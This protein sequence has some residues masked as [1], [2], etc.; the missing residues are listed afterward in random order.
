MKRRH[1]LAA[2]LGLPATLAAPRIAAAAGARVLKFVPQS[3]L[4]VLDPIWTTAFVTRNHAFLVFDT[5]YG[6]DTGYAARPQMVAG[7]VIEDDGKRW[8][9]TLR[10]GLTFHDGTP[11]LGRDCV[12]S[13]RRWGKR[14][15]F[16]QALFAVTD[17][18]AAP[19]DKTIV[20]RLRQPFP[21]L[22]LALG[23]PGANIPVIMPQRL[24]ETDPFKQITEMVGSGPFRFKADERVAGAR[25]VY[26][27][28]NG[29]QPRTDGVPSFTAGP[30][31][32]HFDRVEWV[33]IPDPATAAAALQAGE[34]DWWE[35]ALHDLVPTLRGNA[36]LRVSTL[37][38]TGMI[39]LMRPNHLFPPFDNPA[40][41]R[42]LTGAIAQADFMTAA[43]GTDT[44]FWHDGVGVFCP[45]SPFASSARLTPPAAPDLAAVR[46]AV[47][48]SGYHGEKI[49]LLGVNDIPIVKALCDVGADL[50]TRVGLNVDYV[51]MD[52]GAMVQRR[53]KMDP[54]D[55]GGW[56]LFFT[57]W[58]GLDL[59]SPAVAAALRGNGKA[60]WFGWPTMPKLEQLRQSWLEAPDLD[61][62]KRIAA[63]IQIACLDEVPFYTLGQMFQPTAYRAGLDGMLTGFPIFWNLRAA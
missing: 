38:P 28:F 49:V 35:L 50:L 12:A 47:Q 57:Y 7:H 20:F 18:L 52:A 46:S 13:L 43:A 44:S 5:L 30:K 2:S 31:V 16:G 25:V 8:T 24:A 23:K 36:G 63:D 40:F 60:G 21:L 59:F 33:V 11:V 17:E 1:F 58:G 45:I 15:T 9:L 61:A 4:T 14:D 34:V 6:Q 53:A 26:E 56:N 37:D 3:D 19:D 32:A 42:A 10:D 27:R 51:P 39:G 22:P 41:R 54:P 48:A 29:Y 62:Q 55:Q